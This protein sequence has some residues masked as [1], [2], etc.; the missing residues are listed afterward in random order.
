ML[1]TILLAIK[2]PVASAVFRYTFLEAVL[3]THVPVLVT[4]S[5]A[6]F[7]IFVGKFSSKQSKYI[8]LNISFSLSLIEYLFF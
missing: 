8:T 5:I 7:A 1:F 2:S 4:E 6:F 3:K